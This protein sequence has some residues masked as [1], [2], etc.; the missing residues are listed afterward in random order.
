MLWVKWKA[1]AKIKETKKKKI[2]LKWLEQEPRKGKADLKRWVGRIAHTRP[3]SIKGL[4]FAKF[5]L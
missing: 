3:P 2:F 4:V 5:T 1:A